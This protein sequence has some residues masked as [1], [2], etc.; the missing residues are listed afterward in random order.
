MIVPLS[1]LGTAL[2]NR[3][4]SGR[5]NI[6]DCRPQCQEWGNGELS[7]GDLF[8][9]TYLTRREDHENHAQGDNSSMI[10]NTECLK[11]GTMLTGGIDVSEH[12]TDLEK[13][14]LGM[15]LQRLQQSGYL[16]AENRRG[17]GQVKIEM[18]NAPDAA[19]YETYLS[20]NCSKILA[21]LE[22]IGAITKQGE[23]L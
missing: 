14:C 18:E 9:W 11:A 19:L 15:G 13:S 7:V 16:G 21:Y 12:A 1:L 3:V 2:G 6:C 22:E 5:V 8:E 4:I 17:L 20:A 10:A 23:L